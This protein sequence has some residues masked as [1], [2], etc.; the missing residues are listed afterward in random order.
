MVYSYH[1]AL[2]RHLTDAYDEPA[3]TL[4]FKTDAPLDIKSVLYIPQ[5]SDISTNVVLI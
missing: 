3:Y 2:Y 4:E 1:A 5:V